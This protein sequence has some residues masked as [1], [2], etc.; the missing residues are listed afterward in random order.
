MSIYHLWFYVLVRDYLN[1]LLIWFLCVAADVTE[2]DA[3]RL[4]K[5]SL[6]HPSGRHTCPKG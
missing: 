3:T 6:P 5:H 2:E 4:E 1:V